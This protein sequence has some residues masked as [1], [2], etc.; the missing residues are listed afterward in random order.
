MLEVTWDRWRDGAEPRWPRSSN[1]PGYRSPWPP[2]SRPAVTAL[3]LASDPEVRLRLRP[4][5]RSAGD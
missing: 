2:R 5:L 1:S 3:I 4:T